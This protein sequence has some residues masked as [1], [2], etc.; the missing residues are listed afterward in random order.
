MISWFKEELGKEECKAAESKGIIPEVILDKLL[1]ASPPGGRGL[2]LQP[3]WGASIFDRYAKGSIIGF[4][5]VHGRDDLYRAIIEGLAYS[6]REGLELIEAKGNLRCEKVA[7]SGGASQSDAIC[8]I[9]A[10]ILNRP[11]VRGKTPE[12]SSLG[13]AI[14]TAAGIGEYASIKDAVKEMVLYEKEFI[15]NPE[16]RT[17]YDGLFSVYKKIFD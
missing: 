5:D 14:I 15:P 17:L 16:H 7:A 10:D 6:L 4:G 12:A 8:R 3:Y 13:A 2:I 11:L 1:H 9:T